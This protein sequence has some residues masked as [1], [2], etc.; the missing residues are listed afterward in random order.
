MPGLYRRA[1]PK[2][3]YNIENSMPIPSRAELSAI[4]DPITEYSTAE[5]DETLRGAHQALRDRGQLPEHQG[6][7]ESFEE[8]RDNLLKWASSKLCS[9]GDPIHGIETAIDV[10]QTLLAATIPGDLVGDAQRDVACILAASILKKGLREFCGP[11]R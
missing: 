1:T 8:W 4:L 7:V 6:L 9:N 11:N 3:R 2:L 5:L 10:A